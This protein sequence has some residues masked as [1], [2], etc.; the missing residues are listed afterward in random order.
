MAEYATERTRAKMRVVRY[1]IND[2]TMVVTMRSGLGQPDFTVTYEMNEDGTISR[3][4][5]NP[6]E[7][8]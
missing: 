2:W 6:A 3:S 5:M 7:S 4:D 8:R 1:D